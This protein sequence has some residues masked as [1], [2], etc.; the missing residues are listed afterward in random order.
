MLLG[1]MVG[2]SYG[3]DSKAIFH[4]F[5]GNGNIS[6]SSSCLIVVFYELDCWQYVSMSGSAM[7]I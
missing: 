2:S 5:F 3:S 7:V 1:G 6:A 4:V